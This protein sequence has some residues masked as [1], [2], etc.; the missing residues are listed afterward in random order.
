MRPRSRTKPDFDPAS[1]P[2]LQALG[3]TSS[4]AATTA[5]TSVSHARAFSAGGQ[6]TINWLPNAAKDD[7]NFIEFGAVFKGHFDS[8]FDNQR[9][10]EKDGITYIK[11]N[12]GAQSESSFFRGETGLRLRVTH[13]NQG[14]DVSAGESRSQFRRCKPEPVNQRF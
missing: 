7:E 13:K 4:V 9:F 14:T 8:F 1:S 11:L 6:F 2:A 12:E 10:F 3:A 5:G